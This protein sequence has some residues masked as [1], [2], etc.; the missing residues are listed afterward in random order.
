[1]VKTNGQ[2]ARLSSLLSVVGSQ[3]KFGVDTLEIV[4]V[5]K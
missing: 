3:V 4:F 2:V 5:E 1:L